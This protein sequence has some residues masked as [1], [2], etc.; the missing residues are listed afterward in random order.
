M[1]KLK[2]YRESTFVTVKK[3]LEEGL[4]DEQNLKAYVKAVIKLLENE[5]SKNT[6]TKA[7]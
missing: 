5:L 2:G 6:A 4:H 3:S 7:N 1:A